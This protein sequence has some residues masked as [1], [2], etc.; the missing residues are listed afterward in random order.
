MLRKAKMKE[1]LD[2]QQ[3]TINQGFSP[4]RHR[5]NTEIRRGILGVPLCDLCVSVVKV[6]VNNGH[7]GVKA[8]AHFL[9]A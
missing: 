4:Q 7:S 6:A 3:R 8:I 5:E 1:R 9:A 2:L